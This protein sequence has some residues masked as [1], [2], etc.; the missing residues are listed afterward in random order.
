MKTTM[1][2]LAPLYAGLEKLFRI[3][4]NARGAGRFNPL[5]PVVTLGGYV[6]AVENTAPSPGGPG[7][8]GGARA[9]GEQYRR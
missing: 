3:L 6:A 2:E 7:G 1:D 8:T 4:R 5:G 9:A